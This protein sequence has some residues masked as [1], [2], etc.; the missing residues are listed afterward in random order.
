MTRILVVDDSDVVRD[1]V[2]KALEAG[3][4]EVLEGINGAAGLAMATEN[5]NIGLIICDVN[6]PKMNGLEMCEKI[7]K[8]P[9]FKKTPIFMLTTESSQ[10]L[11]TKGKEIG[12]MAWMVKPFDPT[13][14]VS[15]INKV[16]GK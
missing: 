4:Y 14:M 16:L 13:K 3:G 11:R 12:I 15:A 2:R 8:L 9:T 1:Q 7:K 5:E 10:E 6:M